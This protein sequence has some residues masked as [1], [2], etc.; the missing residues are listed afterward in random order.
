MGLQRK[1]LSELIF[2]VCIFMHM[3]VIPTNTYMLSLQYNTDYLSHNVQVSNCLQIMI[4]SLDAVNFERK[5][6]LKML[7]IR[8]V[9]VSTS[10]DS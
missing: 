10:V 2:T 6:A 8:D 3:Q 1:K 7:E 4:Y 9:R 5:H